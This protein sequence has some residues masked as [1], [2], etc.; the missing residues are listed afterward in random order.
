MSSVSG[1]ISHC[2]L[3]LSP[4]SRP[5]MRSGVVLSTSPQSLSKVGFVVFDIVDQP[6]GGQSDEATSQCCGA[7]GC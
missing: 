5:G 6:P 1:G 2:L 3:L 7:H 4:H